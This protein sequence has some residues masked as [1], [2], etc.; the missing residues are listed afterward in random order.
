MWQAIKKTIEEQ[1]RGC[2][3][4]IVGGEGLAKD[5][6]GRK[7]LYEIET[8][9]FIGDFPDDILPLEAAKILG[10]NAVCSEIVQLETETSRVELFVQPLAPVPTLWVLGAGHI[11]IPVVE[12]GS[13]MGFKT[14][15]LDDRPDFANPV[16]FPKAE[17]VICDDFATT[18]K[19]L[20][21]TENTYIVIVTR[22]HKYDQMCVE[23]LLDSKAAYIGM[24]G[25]RRRVKE[26]KKV[27]EEK[28][29]SKELLA[30]LHSPIGLDIGA[31]TPEEIALSIMAEVVTVRRKTPRLNQRKRGEL[32]IQ[33]SV[34][35]ALANIELNDSEIPA[36][37][38][39]IVEVKGSA[40]R[41][42]G[43][44]MLIFA[45][46]GLVGSVGGGCAEADI[47]R[48]GRM[49]L[50]QNKPLIWN[51]DLTNDIAGEEGMV[52]GG[53]MKVFLQKI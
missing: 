39:T 12:L 11:A 29:F 19:R 7:W 42:P 34:V 26:M 17:E 52:C 30:K 47:R 16:R 23:M 15:V 53:T 50:N 31:E 25:S 33:D 8:D 24:I 28:G 18:I 44:Q 41:K 10:K 5:F 46:G 1:K 9:Q 13:M 3:Q 40:P 6:I 51:V 4:T 27:L 2:I 45:D 36:S 37:L 20:P 21:L 49:V 22:G 32:E 38:A 48:A 14:L 43:A 35:K